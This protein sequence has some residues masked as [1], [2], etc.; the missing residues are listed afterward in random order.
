MLVQNLQDTLWQ[1]AEKA[2]QIGPYAFNRWAAKLGVPFCVT[3]LVTTG[4]MPRF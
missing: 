2:T 4:K 3:H 1:Y